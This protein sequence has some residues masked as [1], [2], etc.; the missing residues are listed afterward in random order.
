ML[1]VGSSLGGILGIALPLGLPDGIL[2][3]SILTLG[4]FDGF[5]LG[6]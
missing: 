2:D 3:G 6:F 5:R 1:T 4:I